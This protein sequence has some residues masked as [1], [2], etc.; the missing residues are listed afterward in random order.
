M[1]DNEFAQNMARWAAAQAQTDPGKSMPI[2]LG[3]KGEVNVGG[4]L[5][6][7]GAA[8]NF[9]GTIIKSPQVRPGM[10]GKLLQEMGFTRGE[11]FEGLKK[12]A[13]A[14]PIQ[15][16]SQS[17]LF[18]QGGPSGGFSSNMGGGGPSGG[19]DMG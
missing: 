16:A 9:D 17:D 15:Q 3:A 19:M 5:S 1:A 11:I 10:L 8:G 18:G 7:K 12:V 2:F 14:G 4:G 13:Q 6:I